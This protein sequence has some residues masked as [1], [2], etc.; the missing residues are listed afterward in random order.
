MCSIGVAKPTVSGQLMVVAPASMAA[1]TT[2]TRYSSSVREASSGENSTSSTYSRASRT[3]SPRHADDFFLGFFELEFTVNLG[4]GAKDV[5]ASL[6]GSLHGFAGAP[7]VFLRASRQAGNSRGGDF[8][9]HGGNGL[10]IAFAGDGEAGLDDVHAQAFQGPGDFQLLLEIERRARR[11]L[12]IAK[13]GVK[14]PVRVSRCSVWYWLH[15]R[16]WRAPIVRTLKRKNPAS[17]TRGVL[18]HVKSGMTLRALA[19]KAKKQ[20]KLEAQSHHVPFISV[21]CPPSQYPALE[22]PGSFRETSDSANFTV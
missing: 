10:K 14:N 8:R 6:F 17:H 21:R 20:A 5:D 12:A 4:G 11:L 9:G 19:A 1:W 22:V 15:Q 13:S 16:T 3:F 18:F 7:H 2:S